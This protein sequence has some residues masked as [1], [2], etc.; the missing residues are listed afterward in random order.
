M[1]AQAMLDLPKSGPVSSVGTH[2]ANIR[3]SDKNPASPI[4]RPTSAG[5]PARSEGGLRRAIS[6]CGEL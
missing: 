6:L 2:F 5:P 1:A 4:P 3:R